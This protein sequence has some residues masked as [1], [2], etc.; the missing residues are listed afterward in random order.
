[1]QIRLMFT[2]RGVQLLSGLGLGREGGEDGWEQECFER[3]E[4]AMSSPLG[5]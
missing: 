5:Q 1:M 2:L 3:I 4:A